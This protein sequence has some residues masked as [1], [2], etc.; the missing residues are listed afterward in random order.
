M[1]PTSTDVGAVRPDRGASPPSSLPG[2]RTTR[3]CP[4]TKHWRRHVS[5]YP[6]GL[7]GSGH[8]HQPQLVRILAI[9]DA[10]DAM[11]SSR[12]YQ[13][14]RLMLADAMAI[15]RLQAGTHFDP[16][17]VGAVLLRGA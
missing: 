9:A 10:F 8:P 7:A 13:P 5:R 4:I 3:S 15:I 6:E 17:L 11:T 2:R 12:G 1:Q 14:T 16:D